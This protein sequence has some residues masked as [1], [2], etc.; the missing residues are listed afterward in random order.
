MVKYLVAIEMPRVRFPD[1]AA[2]FQSFL[3]PNSTL[4]S[5]Y[6]YRSFLFT[7]STDTHILQPSNLAIYIQSKLTTRKRR[8]SSCSRIGSPLPPLPSYFLLLQH[9]PSRRDV[10]PLFSIAHP[11][12]RFYT[13]VG[14]QC[15]SIYFG[16]WSI[17]KD[18][19]RG[20]EV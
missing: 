17:V 10:S 14:Q 9:R 11:M 13:S 3:L 1:G 20:H 5:S 8:T 19:A 15:L 6:S 18:G 7:L 4:A 2:S 16:P 12:L